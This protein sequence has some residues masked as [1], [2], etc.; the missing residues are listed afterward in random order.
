MKSTMKGLIFIRLGL[1][2]DNSPRTKICYLS[3][4]YRFV[5]NLKSTKRYY[6]MY[7]RRNCIIKKPK[8]P[9]GYI[10]FLKNY[11]LQLACMV[12]TTILSIL[13]LILRIQCVTVIHIERRVTLNLNKLVCVW[14]MDIL[15]IFSF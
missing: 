2:K 5:P 7:L 6:S 14:R 12:K 8:R 13:V 11:S 3:R 9:M 1:I 4:D 10:A 15:C